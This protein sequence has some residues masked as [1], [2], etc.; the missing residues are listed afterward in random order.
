MGLFGR[1]KK[2]KGNYREI[3]PEYL[4]VLKGLVYAED[5]ILPGEA[6]KLARVYEHVQAG[7]AFEIRKTMGSRTKSSPVVAVFSE[8][9]Y[10]AQIFEAVSEA[11]GG[12]RYGIYLEG[13]PGVIKTFQFPG[14]SRYQPH[15]RSK[16]TIRKEQRDNLARQAAIY[17]QQEIDSGSELGG[18]LK[19]AV[20]SQSL[21]IDVP[22][23]APEPSQDERLIA[24]Y[25]EDH[26]EVKAAY[27]E[28]KLRE[29]GVKS[30][31]TQTE[32]ERTTEQLSQMADQ[33]KALRELEVAGRP[34][35]NLMRE[36]VQGIAAALPTVL[37]LLIDHK[38]TP[39]K[40]PTEPGAVP[41]E[42]EVVGTPL[43]AQA[44]TELASNIGLEPTSFQQ[45]KTSKRDSRRSRMAEV[46][47][48]EQSEISQSQEFASTVDWSDLETGIHSDPVDYIA[49]LLE[50]GHDKSNGHDALLWGLKDPDTF[51]AALDEAVERLRGQPGLGHDYE[52][53]VLVQKHLTESEKGKQ[54]LTAACANRSV[55]Q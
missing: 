43:T 6:R 14:P 47:Q 55:P 36:L 15:E 48:T 20:I 50:M 30:H 29:L 41:P 35:P 1:I 52:I 26:P 33:L 54:W 46:S 18:Q 13:A 3:P 4:D 27:V 25:L 17:V 42:T 9:P 21:G 7:G 53:A 16:K 49:H 39:D 11:Y 44:P 32:I 45:P 28:A 23:L 10:E 12:G 40:T 31:E 34:E 24:E 2:K 8:F 37:S 51:L 19:L 5:F 22:E 38:G